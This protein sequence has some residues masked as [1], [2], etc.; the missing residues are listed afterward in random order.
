M[1][2]S[3][4]V[5]ATAETVNDADQFTDPNPWFC[6][7]CGRMSHPNHFGSLHRLPL[8]DVMTKVTHLPRTQAEVAANIEER[9]P[10]VVSALAHLERNWS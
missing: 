5:P 6:T 2:S 1:D 8:W 10:R 9:E 4:P 7:L 3:S